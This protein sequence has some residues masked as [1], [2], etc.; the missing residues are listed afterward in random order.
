MVE[1][2]HEPSTA[3]ETEATMF[4]KIKEHVVGWESLTSPDDVIFRRLSGLSN[5]CYKVSPKDAEL[6]KTL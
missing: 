4:A 5:A 3:E 1:S 6:A 2:F